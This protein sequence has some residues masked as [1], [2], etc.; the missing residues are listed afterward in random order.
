MAEVVNALRRIGA[1]LRAEHRPRVPQRCFGAF[2]G[3][4]GA[5]VP[6][7]R[8]SIARAIAF[9]EWVVKCQ[10]VGAD[11]EVLWRRGI[12]RWRLSLSGATIQSYLDDELRR[13]VQD[14]R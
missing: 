6:G 5:V 11:P 14:P 2:G 9:E 1:A 12:E 4:S 3:L 13:W 7:L 10:V 8:Q